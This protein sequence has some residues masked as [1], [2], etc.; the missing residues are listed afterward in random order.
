[1]SSANIYTFDSTLPG[2]S[3]INNERGQI[4]EHIEVCHWLHVDMKKQYHGHN[5]FDVAQ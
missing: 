2:R 4:Q 1:M 5:P 3:L